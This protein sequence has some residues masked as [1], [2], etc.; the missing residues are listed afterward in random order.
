MGTFVLLKKLL[1][2][3]RVRLTS[4]VLCWLGVWIGDCLARV[5]NLEKPIFAVLS[6]P[7]RSLAEG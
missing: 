7:D 4:G 5:V 1:P 6:S 2:F 3:V